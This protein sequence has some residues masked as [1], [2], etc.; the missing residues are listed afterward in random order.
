[1]PAPDIKILKKLTKYFALGV[2]GLIAA[3]FVGYYAVYLPIAQSREKK[4]FAEAKS[5]LSEIKSQLVTAIGEPAQDI[6]RESCD[7]QNVKNNKGSLSCSVSY[8]IIYNGKD[9]SSADKVVW[10]A[11]ELIG[12]G[13]VRNLLGANFTG[14]KSSQSTYHNSAY[15]DVNKIN[16]LSCGIQITYPATQL[17]PR[18][19][20]ISGTESLALEATCSGSAK[21]EYFQ[22]DN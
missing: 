15:I 14:F 8:F 21:G 18:P 7:R 2:F 12:T 16:S 13:E 19:A 1:M 22:L 3:F 11:S 20:E 5:E 4:Q 6:Y 10:A 9:S 17:T